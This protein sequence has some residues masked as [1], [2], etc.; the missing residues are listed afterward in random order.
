MWQK[1]LEGDAQMLGGAMIPY[2]KHA[3][4]RHLRSGSLARIAGKD[5][6]KMA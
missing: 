3:A 2:R 4:V 5:L 6:L 1:H